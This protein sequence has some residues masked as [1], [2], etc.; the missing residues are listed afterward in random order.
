MNTIHTFN[1]VQFEPNRPTP[2][3]SYMLIS[4]SVFYARVSF[5]KMKL[6]FPHSTVYYQSDAAPQIA[7]SFNNWQPQDMKSAAKPFADLPDGSWYK[8]DVR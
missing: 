7:G 8:A 1:L 4:I 6:P 2:D 3:E 5:T